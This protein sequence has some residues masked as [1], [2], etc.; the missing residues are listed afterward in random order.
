MEQNAVGDLVLVEPEAFRALADPARL[1][2][3]DAIRRIGPATTEE[4]TPWVGD[5]AAL[6]SHLAALEEQGFIEQDGG[7]WRTI[8]KGI[9]FEIPD[10][11]A[12]QAAARELTNVML[13]SYAD[14]PR[15]WVADQAPRL[16]LEW[17]RASGLFNARVRMTSDEVRDV[18]EKLRGAARTADHPRGREDAGRRHA[19]APPCVLPAGAAARRMTSPG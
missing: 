19:R 4:L 11:P 6:G 10:D 14:V 5:F 12:G 17:A 15:D 8:G 9:V 18:Q 7:K 13:L 2:L 1:A 3:F 16:S